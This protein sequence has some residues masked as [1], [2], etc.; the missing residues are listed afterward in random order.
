MS[1]A[2]PILA[3]VRFVRARV[4]VRVAASLPEC[5]IQR[6]RFGT[7]RR[8]SFAEE[9]LGDPAS[10]IPEPL[11][12]AKSCIVTIKLRFGTL[13]LRLLFWLPNRDVSKLRFDA[14]NL[15]LP[16]VRLFSKG[17]PCMQPANISFMTAHFE[18]MLS[19]GEYLN[20][21]VYL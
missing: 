11:C 10:F 8:Q 19:C 5:E 13:N 18:Q 16:F 9:G 4:R 12:I 21:M 6:Q 3:R 1:T 2:G 15:R 14:L 20:S 7:Q 17:R